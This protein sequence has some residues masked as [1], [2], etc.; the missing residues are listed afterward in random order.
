M[1]LALRGA[2]VVDGTGGPRRRADVEVTD[3]RVTAVGD[4][5]RSSGTEEV[6][7]DGLVLCPGFVDIHT[8]FD[9]QVFWDRDLTPSS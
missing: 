7:L 4:V 8:H 6:D 5:G 3:G 1:R 2:T 9:A